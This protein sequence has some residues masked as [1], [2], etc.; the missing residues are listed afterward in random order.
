MDNSLKAVDKTLSS[1]SPKFMGQSHQMMIVSA[2]GKPPNRKEKNEAK[3]SKKRLYFLRYLWRKSSSNSQ[4]LRRS[5]P[6]GLLKRQLLR[7]R[8]KGFQ[9]MN[10]IQE[11]KLVELSIKSCRPYAKG[12]QVNARVDG[13]ESEMTY[14]NDTK[15]SALEQAKRRIAKEGR[16]PH[17][18]YRGNR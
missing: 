6:F 12:W 7:I 18:P 1:C 3:N 16:L 10:Y 14:Y 2:R 5:P 13:V 15:S 8:E 17:E 4:N 9:L 11:G